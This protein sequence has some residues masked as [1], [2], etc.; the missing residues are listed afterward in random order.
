VNSWTYL[1]MLARDG[2]LRFH[3]VEN[4][5]YAGGLPDLGAAPRNTAVIRAAASGEDFAVD[6]TLVDA[7][8]VPPI[9]P[10]SVWTASWPPRISAENSSEPT[11]A[12]PN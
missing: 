7:G 12:G 8:A 10:L 5:A 6:P 1:T 11:A 9:F 3:T 2:L 4:L